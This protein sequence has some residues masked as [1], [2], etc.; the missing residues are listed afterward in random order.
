MRA[1][2]IKNNFSIS[3]GK[4]NI[5]VQAFDVSHGLIKATGFVMEKNW[6]H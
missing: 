3:K 6:I 5:K 4:T 2:I 1:K